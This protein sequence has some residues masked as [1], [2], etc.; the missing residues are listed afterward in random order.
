[1]KELKSVAK[2]PMH[3]VL[4]KIQKYEEFLKFHFLMASYGFSLEKQIKRNLKLQ[5][6]ERIRPEFS[7]TSLVFEIFF[8]ATPCMFSQK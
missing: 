3:R 7:E 1:M 5:N 4:Y 8:S 2:C 6:S